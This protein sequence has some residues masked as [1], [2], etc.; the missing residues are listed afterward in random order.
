MKTRIAAILLV[1]GL[2]LLLVAAAPAPVETLPPAAL[3]GEPAVKPGAA[4]G[5]FVWAD[6]KGVH[7][8][9]TSDGKQALFAGSVE[10]D[11]PFG[12][13]DRV[14]KTAGGWVQGHGDRI[15]MFS[16]TAATALDGFDL[17]APAGAVA[18]LDAQIDG[19]PADVGLVS[20]GEAGAHA[21][22]LPVKFVVR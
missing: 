7:V 3:K 4:K 11:K 22:A 17:E 5:L 6:A 8:R 10:L 12:K 1:A 20:F 18:K 21:K 19:N 13:I 2:A 15:V 16:A 9:W 14:S